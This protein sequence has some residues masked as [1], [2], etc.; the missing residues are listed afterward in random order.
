MQT[1]TNTCIKYI[2]LESHT[3]IHTLTLAID[4]QVYIYI[5]YLQPHRLIYTHTHTHARAH[6]LVTYRHTQQKLSINQQTNQYNL[7]RIFTYTHTHTH[8]HNTTN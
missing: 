3:R 6:N 5:W 4:T 2:Y 7:I 8:T 1:K